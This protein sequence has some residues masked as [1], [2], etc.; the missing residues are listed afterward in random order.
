M[1][2]LSRSSSFSR[3]SSPSTLSLSALRCLRRPVT[4]ER[5]R[6]RERERNKKTNIRV[7]VLQIMKGTSKGD[8]TR[9][10]VVD[11]T[12]RQGSRGERSAH[13]SAGW[14]QVKSEY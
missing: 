1:R 3:W 10:D 12:R 13:Y 7:R 5:K 8:G 2:T 11:R 14:L 9:V 6:E 4:R